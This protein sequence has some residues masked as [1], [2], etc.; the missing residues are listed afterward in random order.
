MGFKMRFWFWFF[1]FI[2]V[3]SW[4][5]HLFPKRRATPFDA[6][7]P[8]NNRKTSLNAQQMVACAKCGTYVLEQEA[9]QKAGHYYCSKTCLP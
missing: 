2:I 6:A 5:K 8:Q 4:W 7:P 9:L 1:V 3:W